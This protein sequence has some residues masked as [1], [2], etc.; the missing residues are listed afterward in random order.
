MMVYFTKGIT[1][2]EI[3]CAHVITQFLAMLAQTALVLIFAFCIFDITNHGNILWVIIIT[4][5]AGAC[6]MTFGWYTT[7]IF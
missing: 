3:M 4:V 7:I 1:A 5:M 6:G 2:L